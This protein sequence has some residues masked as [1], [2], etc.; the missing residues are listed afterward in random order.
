MCSVAEYDALKGDLAFKEGEL[1]KSK[2]TTQSLQA[3][4]VNLQANL[5]KVYTMLCG[6]VYLIISQF[7]YL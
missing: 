6:F 2:Y 7:S 3:E 1:K 5:M 4:H